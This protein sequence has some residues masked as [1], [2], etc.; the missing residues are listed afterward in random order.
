MPLDLKN[1]PPPLLRRLAGLGIAAGGVFI[2]ALVWRQ[3]ASAGMFSLYGALAGP[4]FGVL[5]LG[6]ILFPGYRE[7]RLRRGEDIS[8]LEGM[9]LLTPRWHGILVGMGL[10]AVVNLGLLK[11]WW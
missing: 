8:Q 1:A 10:A 6:L 7:E 4:A 3:A 11:G 2:V 5:G 9:A